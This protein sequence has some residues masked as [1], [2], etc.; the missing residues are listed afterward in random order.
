MPTLPKLLT[1]T[2]LSRA[3]FSTRAHSSSSSTPVNL[4]TTPHQQTSSGIKRHNLITDTFGKFTNAGND[5]PQAKE[6]QEVS[7]MKSK[8]GDKVAKVHGNKDVVKETEGSKA[9]EEEVVGV[10][11]EEEDEDWR[12]APDLDSQLQPDPPRSTLR[13][14]MSKIPSYNKTQSNLETD[15]FGKSV[16][17]KHTTA[18]SRGRKWPPKPPHEDE[19]RQTPLLGSVRSMHNAEFSRVECLTIS[20]DSCTEWGTPFE[21]KDD[22]EKHFDVERVSFD[23]LFEEEQALIRW[24]RRANEV[25]FWGGE[26][27]EREGK[28]LDEDLGE[29]KQGL[30]KDEE[31]LDEGKEVLE[32]DNRAAHAQS[33]V[34]YDVAGSEE[35]AFI[36]QAQVP[37]CQAVS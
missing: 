20:R 33:S 7:G 4:P 10:K 14:T 35:E 26:G 18:L 17:P 8:E 1:S 13:Q 25:C 24:L 3:P 19:A 36:L 11:E 2:S 5:V 21:A 30:E 37:S 12:D 31:D 29:G 16:H 23:N 34:S 22:G 32:K 27:A 6:A 9:G 15:S 28:V